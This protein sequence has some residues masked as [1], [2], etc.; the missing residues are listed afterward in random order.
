MGLFSKKRKGPKA[1]DFDGSVLKG[2]TERTET[3]SRVI[4]KHGYISVRDGVLTVSGEEKA[5][6]RCPEGS[7]SC[8]PLMSGDGVIVSGIDEN[9]LDRSLI[10]YYLYY[11]K[12][13]P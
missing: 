10:C 3:G 4:A 13:E 5:L 12:L 6:F 2:I 8:S 7:V 1:A 9:G 11:R